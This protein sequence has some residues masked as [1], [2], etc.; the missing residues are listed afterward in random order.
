MVLTD[1]IEKI[2]KIKKRFFIILLLKSLQVNALMRIK[3]M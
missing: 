1:K 2:V 3:T